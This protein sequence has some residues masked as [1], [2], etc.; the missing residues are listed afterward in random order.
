MILKFFVFNPKYFL[1][2]FRR[3]I[4]Y[5]HME[6]FKKVDFIVTPTT[7]Y[8]SLTDHRGNECN[9]NGANHDN[10]FNGGLNLDMG[11]YSPCK[12][13][14]NRICIYHTYDDNYV[15]F[16]LDLLEDYCLS[17]LRTF[18]RKSNKYL[19]QP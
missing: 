10:K 17:T 13:D 16:F 18:I 14:P 6:I 7:G 11:C 5:H 15:P 8:V 4:M 19:I 3:R 1:V 9:Y 2:G 12:S